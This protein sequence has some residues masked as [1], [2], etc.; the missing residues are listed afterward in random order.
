MA[1][2]R[3]QAYILCSV[4]NKIW[5][6]HFFIISESDKLVDSDLLCR[7]LT[8]IDFNTVVNAQKNYKNSKRL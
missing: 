3:D 8:N 6:I 1:Y 5:T 4:L 7:Q 2:D